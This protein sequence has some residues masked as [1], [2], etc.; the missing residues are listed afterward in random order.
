[1]RDNILLS[2][3]VPIY[4]IKEYIDKCIASICKQS[5]KNL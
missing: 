5:Y 3:I 4:T 1:M 2:V